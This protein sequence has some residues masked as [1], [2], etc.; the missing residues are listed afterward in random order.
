MKQDHELELDS[1]KIKVKNLNTTL[2]NVEKTL[3]A[4]FE[5]FKNQKIQQLEMEKN[6]LEIKLETQPR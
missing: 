4:E 5:S 1:H 6:A 3:K 2:E